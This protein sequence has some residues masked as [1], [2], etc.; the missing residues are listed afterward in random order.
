[1]TTYATGN[2]L[3]SMSAKDL[4]DNAENLDFFLNGKAQGYPDRF[5]EYRISY[6]GMEVAFREAQSYRDEAFKYAIRNSGFKLLGE[7]APGVTITTYNQVVRY[8]GELYGLATA[9]EAP[10]TLTGVWA[11]DSAH[12]VSRGDAALRQDLN[13]LGTKMIPHNS[14]QP[15]AV[16]QMTNQKLAE[17]GS[18]PGD[19]GAKGDG[20]ANDTSRYMTAEA[21]S[22]VVRLPEGKTYALDTG[23][24]PSKMVVGGGKI[25]IGSA[26]F[27]GPEML[28]D[29]FRTSLY[30]T[31]ESYTEQIGFPGGNQGNLTVMISPGGR[32]TG[33]LNRCT[34]VATGAPQKA[35]SLD[36]CEIF[37]NGVM[38]HARY[39]ERVT[40]F[41]SIACQWLGSND[42]LGDRHEWFVNAGG[43][44]PGQA[45]WDY[46]GMETRNPG[47]GS[48]IAAFN[49]FATQPTDCGRTVAGGRN[50]LNG[51]VMARNCVAIGYRAGAGCY[52]IENMVILGTDVFR[53]GVFLR[54]SVGAG[55][56]AGRFWQEGE[57][58]ALFGYNAGGNAV[59]G[60]RNTLLGSFAG[61]DYTEL[62]DC[63]LIGHGAGNSIG[64][65]TLSNV[66][67]L[68]PS[69]TLP[70]LS[71]RLTDFAA[72][73]NILPG[74]IKGNFH[75]R[76]NDFGAE[77]PAHGLAD[78]VVV[79]NSVGVG[80]T[81]RSPADAS[82]NIFFA[83]PG[84]TQS[85]GM[86]YTHSNDTLSL[87]AGGQSQFA[88]ND[89][90]LYPSQDNARSIGTASRRP[91]VIYAAT[92]A[93]STSDGNMKKIRGALSDPEIRAWSTV[94]TKVFQF[95]DMIE[96]KGE[97]AARLHAGYIAQDVQDA[98]IAEGLDPS[99]YA[100]WCEDEVFVQVTKRRVTKRQKVVEVLESIE[101]IE[102]Q[103]GMAVVKKITRPILQP[104]FE[105]L[106]V[107]DEQGNSVEEAGGGTRTCSVPVMED[108]EEEFEASEPSGVR[109]GLRYEQCLVFEAAYLRS[110]IAN[111]DERIDTEIADLRSLIADQQERIRA[112]EAA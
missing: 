20:V 33:N 10:Y 84:S 59:R 93:I 62:N 17:I 26:I 100:L 13:N 94:Q 106:P 55:A 74:R 21:G 88:I 64:G 34:I 90:A 104:Q 102:V 56:M 38:Q 66:F 16:S 95:L 19:F 65:G 109:L 92:G 96:T 83:R 98:F 85:G 43:L 101:E 81:L 86:S 70:L 30:C 57:R 45:G 29:I 4:L 51:T 67:C 80:M 71:G 11:T 77:E 72:G 5:F 37:G 6:F 73:V 50:A 75:V 40:A 22:D 24:T 76:T 52:A 108:H 111:Q 63:I 58:N 32:N 36:R 79:E 23:Y 9:T 82:G 61:Y 97:E 39:A 28:Y 91:S 103:D 42:P 7:Y 3:G 44:V 48:R 12:L 14:G 54:D 49:G 60:S 18:T 15:G 69:G 27:T 68:G 31:P 110:I 2:P 35:I 78:D 41:G 25:R 87:I 105:L 89:E 46:Q 1:M 8:Q 107:I 53:D 99:R 112:L 47:I